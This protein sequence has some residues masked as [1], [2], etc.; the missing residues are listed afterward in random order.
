MNISFEIGG[1]KVRPNQVKN[2]L[3]KAIL[4]N[5]SDSIAKALRGV[6]CP[7]HGGRPTVRCSGRKLDKLTFEVT[8]CCSDL[9]ERATAKLR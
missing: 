7:E 6:T 2:A 9:I 4:T 8:G 1:R 5:L 3:E